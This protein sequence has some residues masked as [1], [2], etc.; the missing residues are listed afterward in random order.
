[1]EQQLSKHGLSAIRMCA[2]LS[3]D[4]AYDLLSEELGNRWVMDDVENSICNLATVVYLEEWLENDKN[5]RQTI[6]SFAFY[7]Y[8]LQ[9]EVALRKEDED[10]VIEAG[11]EA[12][13]KSLRNAE[14]VYKDMHEQR[15]KQAESEKAIKQSLPEKTSKKAGIL[16]DFIALRFMEL[17]ATSITHPRQLTIFDLMALRKGLMS[18]TSDKGKQDSLARAYEDYYGIFREIQGMDA[19]KYVIATMRRFI[20]WR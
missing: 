3:L 5:A 8:S 17:Y 14:V 16:Y 6:N 1:M 12:H 15:V 7:P 19:R 2:R 9:S 18:V 4:K 20:S 10:A 11:Q 13:I